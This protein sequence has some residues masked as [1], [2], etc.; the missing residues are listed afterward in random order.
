MKACVTKAHAREQAKFDKALGWIPKHFE[1]SIF[2]APEDEGFEYNTMFKRFNDVWQ[3][4]AR[5]WNTT[6]RNSLLKADPMWFFNTFSE[7]SGV[8]KANA[9]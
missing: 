6:H 7:K 9:A 4:Q 8:E 2:N 5:W 1:R 3:K